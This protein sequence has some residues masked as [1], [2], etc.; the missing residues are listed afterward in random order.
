MSQPYLLL[1]EDGNT[2]IL[3]EPSAYRTHHQV[4]V[5][6]TESGLGNSTA[7]MFLTKSE[8]LSLARAIIRAANEEVTR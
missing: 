6:V 1:V 5:Q 8:A 4:F 7:A 3:V 2:D